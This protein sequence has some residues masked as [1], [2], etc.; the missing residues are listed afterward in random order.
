MLKRESFT[1]FPTFFGQKLYLG[2]IWGGKTGFA[3]ILRSRWLRGHDN[4]YAYLDGKIWRLLSLKEQSREKEWEGVFKNKKVLEIVL[5]C[6]KMHRKNVLSQKIGVE[7]VVKLFLLDKYVQCI[8]CDCVCTV[9]A[10]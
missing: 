7:N 3:N 1:R 9:Y 10:L 8:A 5:A 4:E 2:P 6:Y